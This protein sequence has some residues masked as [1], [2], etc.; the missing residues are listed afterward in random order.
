MFR[1]TQRSLTIPDAPSSSK[2]QSASFAPFYSEAGLWYKTM[3]FCTAPR[4]TSAPRPQ[5]FSVDSDM[6]C[7]ERMGIPTPHL[8][9][10]RSLGIKTTCFRH[11][12]I[13]KYPWRRIFHPFRPFGPGARRIR[14][15]DADLY[16]LEPR[17]NKAPSPGE[18]TAMT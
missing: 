18:A 11:T 2:Y 13:N 7:F 17:E 4:S 1:T 8:E 3:V 6:F 15:T 10:L 14:L 12:K 16:T 5:L 9:S